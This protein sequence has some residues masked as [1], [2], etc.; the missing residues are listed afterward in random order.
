MK[1]HSKLDYTEILDALAAAKKAGHVT[2]D[3]QC[4]VFDGPRGSRTHRRAFEIQLGTYDKDSLPEGYKDSRTGKNMRV[5]HYKNSGSSGAHNEWAT[6][7]S[8]WSATYD[9][10][11]W[12]MAET[13]KLDPDA[14][15]GSRAGW[16]YDGEENFHDKTEDRFK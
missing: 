10:W 13:F 9:E 6:G 16:G 15:W 14:L 3:V 11:G 7:G 8:I 2:P 1:L 4:V 5:R 12:F